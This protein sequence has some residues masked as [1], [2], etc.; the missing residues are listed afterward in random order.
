MAAGISD[1]MKPERFTGGDNFKRWQTWVKFW[2][3]S[4]KIWFIQAMVG[5]S[6]ADRLLYSK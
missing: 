1:V 5:G 6:F 2:L 4:M 3:M